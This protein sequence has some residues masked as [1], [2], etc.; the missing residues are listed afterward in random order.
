MSY[1]PIDE[2]EYAMRNVWPKGW[3]GATVVTAADSVVEQTS[4]KGN[5]MFKTQ[6]DV[7]NQS[8]AFKRI[9]CYIIASGQ[10]AWQLRSAAE[11]FGVLDQYRAGTLRPDD[12]KGRSGFVKLGIDEDETGQYEPKN[13]IADYRKELPKKVAQTMQQ[14][15]SADLTDDSIPF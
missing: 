3:Y 15:H 11:A 6:I 14:P 13:V 4:A 2:K 12:L 5:V 1:Q 7:Y 10:A 9:T 8:G